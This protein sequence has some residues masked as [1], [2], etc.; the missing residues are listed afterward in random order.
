M[1]AVAR[2][3][4]HASHGWGRKATHWSGCECTKCAQQ[5]AAVGKH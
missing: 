4:T 2:G 5:T 3:A 1:I